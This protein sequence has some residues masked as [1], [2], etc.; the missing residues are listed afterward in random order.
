MGEK[1]PWFENVTTG[2]RRAL[3]RRLK[4]G[5]R[6]V[7]RL[8]TADGQFDYDSQL[9]VVDIH[10]LT[11]RGRAFVVGA[12]LRSVYE[13]REEMGDEHPTTLIVLDELNKYAPKE[14]GGPIKEMLLDVA[15]RGRSLGIVLL[16]A[17]Q[18][19]SQVEGRVV[20]NSALRVVGRLEAAE[21]EQP[22]YGWLTGTMRRRSTLLPP[23]TMVVAQPEVP[24]PLV[25][26][27]PFPAWATRS[28]EVAE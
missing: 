5:A 4:A 7:A 16:G 3:M 15:E 10:Q 23:G 2:T 20:G 21:S 11:D 28:S 17:E 6:Q 26:R 8:I 1:N 22:A 9:N 13:R 25:M 19:A 18:T 27:F 14:G 24:V 12:V